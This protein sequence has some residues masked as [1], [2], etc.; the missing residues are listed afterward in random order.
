[1]RKK[2]LAMSI[3]SILTAA[4][5]SSL[6]AFDTQGIDN[7][8]TD[9]GPILVQDQRNILAAYQ[10]DRHSPVQSIHNLALSPNGR[11]DALIFPLFKQEIG[12]NNLDGWKTEFVVRNTDP[13]HA[14]VAKVALYDKDISKELFDF[15]VYLSAAD[16]VRFSLADGVLTSSDG[17]V[18][19]KVSSPE[20]SGSDSVTFASPEYPF[21]SAHTKA[22]DELKETNAGYVIVYGMGQA[23]T[24]DPVAGMDYHLKHEKLFKNYRSELDVCRPTWRTG[25]LE[26]RMQVGTFVRGP[27]LLNPYYVAAPNQPENCA[28]LSDESEADAQAAA[29]YVTSTAAL[30]AIAAAA[31][32]AA[33][34]IVVDAEVVADAANVDLATA[35]TVASDA[36]VALD[37]ANTAGIPAD[38]AAA[39]AVALAAATNASNASIAANNAATAVSAA[40]TTLA[41]ANSEFGT[42]SALATTASSNYAAILA[43]TSAAVPGN[44]F[45]DVGEHLTGTVRL[46]NEVS[47]VERDMLLPGKAIKNFTDGNKIIWTEGELSFLQDRR[48]VAAPSV[49]AKYSEAGICDDAKAFLVKKTSYTFAKK[50]APAPSNLKN[51]LTI[52]QPYKRVLVQLGNDDHYWKEPRFPPYVKEDYGHFSIAYTV[53]NEDELSSKVYYGSSP[54]ND[55]PVTI[56]PELALIADLEVGTEF[57]KENGFALVNLRGNTNGLPAVV[58]QM[59]GTVVNTEPQTNWIYSQTNSN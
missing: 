31:A 45:G 27:D 15:D 22:G 50:D 56:Y 21:S 11:G 14:I 3:A 32:S 8:C 6:M 16:V 44:F 55:I 40:N 17:S 57:E 59:V 49:W 28:Y 47:G 58:T 25:R 34:I 35:Y 18:P 26:K 20:D 52:T 39:E 10:G 2:I 30:E 4:T 48:I 7:A 9:L 33:K 42:A 43:R 41:A 24:R 23:S 13:K 36:A 5:T 38:I 19:L 1:M 12:G 37:L 54:F 46:Y 29:A 51:L 53:Y